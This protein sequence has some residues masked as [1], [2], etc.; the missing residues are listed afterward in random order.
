MSISTCFDTGSTKV[1]PEVVT[2]RHAATAAP[3]VK[4]A[5]TMPAHFAQRSMSASIPQHMFGTM[6][7]SASEM[8]RRALDKSRRACTSAVCN[9]CCNLRRSQD[10]TFLGCQCPCRLGC[11]NPHLR[12]APDE[13]H[14]LRGNP[15]RAGNCNPNRRRLS[16]AVP[17]T[18]IHHR[19]GKL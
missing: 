18:I 5:L 8:R 7:R 12:C 11:C 6:L 17:G 3:T 15:R 1:A 9:Q 2:A 19:Q 13:F 4:P 10:D 16:N 14:A